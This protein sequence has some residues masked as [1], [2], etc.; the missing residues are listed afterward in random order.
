MQELACKTLLV[1]AFQTDG[2]HRSHFGQAMASVQ[3]GT[4][5]TNR[6]WKI[7]APPTLTLVSLALFCV[8]MPEY[9]WTINEEPPILV[10]AQAFSTSQSSLRP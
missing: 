6:L 2:Y 5:S 1:R 9:V 8:A 3:D 10:T 4:V 7:K